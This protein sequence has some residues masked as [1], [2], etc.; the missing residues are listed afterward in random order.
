MRNIKLEDL[1]SFSRTEEL[2]R[3]A[4]HL[5]LIKHSENQAL[6]WLGAAVRAKSVAGDPV[7]IFAGIV[8]QGLWRN[9]TQEQEERAR[10]A[11]HR[12]RE[13]NPALF[14]LDDGRGASSAVN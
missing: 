5:G 13:L 3:Q 12:Y 14:F 6:N 4:V 8:R 10:A 9:I 1:Q 11:L 2:Y 7:R